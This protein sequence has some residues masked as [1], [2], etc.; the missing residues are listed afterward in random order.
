MAGNVGIVS[1][2]KKSGVNVS[3]RIQSINFTSNPVVDQSRNTGGKT[4][5]KY[6]FEDEHAVSI[7]AEF[8]T[9]PTLNT[10]DAIVVANCPITAYNGTYYLDGPPQVKEESQAYIV[11]TIAAT[12]YVA[13]D[14][15]V[16]FAGS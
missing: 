15:E 2:V 12:K 10:A 11:L 13:V 14:T 7:D 4:K 8:A 16:E 5:A 6:H 3:G 9:A 1:T